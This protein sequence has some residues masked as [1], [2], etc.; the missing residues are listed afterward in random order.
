MIKTLSIDI[1]TFS[2]VD[3]ARCGVYRYVESPDFRVLLFG[4]RADDG[5]VK[6]CELEKKEELPPEILFALLDDSVIKWAFNAAF[7]RVCISSYLWELGLLK[8]GTYL[9]PVSWRC[10][11]VWCGYL[12]LP[13]SLA[14]VGAELG[15]DKQKLSEGK[16]LIRFFC[17]PAIPSLLN[18]LSE[19]NLP[20]SAPDKWKDFVS[21]NLRDVEAE[22]EIKEK[23]AKFPVPDFLWE[24][25]VLDQS[26]NDRG[27]KVDL[28]MVR[29]AMEL[30]AESKDSLITELQRLTALA[31]PNSVSQI[32]QW[33]TDHGTEVRDLSKKQVKDLLSSA[34]E[35][36]RPVLLLR[37]QLAKSSVK[38]YVA[39][40]DCACVD[41]RVRGM[42]Q[43]YG[44][45]RSGRWAGRGVQL[46]NLPQNHL[47]DLRAV[48]E[49]VA[50][51]DGETLNL[52]YDSVPDVL[53]EL[54]RKIG[55]AHV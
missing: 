44:A 42:F 55:R 36:V 21:Y 34:S 54:I 45:S 20:W 38:K 17:K 29:G 16:S 53:S 2:S 12:G 51:R 3:L 30:D 14:G 47:P 13:M 23:L 1:E 46:Q 25:Y 26:I 10:S 33:L 22:C 18:G 7:E 41:S 6:V 43:F 37:Q 8:A 28:Q 50:Q 31:N 52:L 19:R 5:P 15:L 49:L 11:M 32:R 40:N 48:R 4:Y 27:I 39:M 24:Q 9:S 35:E